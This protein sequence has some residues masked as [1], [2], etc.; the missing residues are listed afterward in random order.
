MARG[1]R[2][3]LEEKIQAK[4]ELIAALQT[5]V[6]SEQRELEELFAEKRRRELEIVND[7]IEESGLDV[8]EV[9]EVL[10]QYIENQ[11]ASAS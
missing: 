11:A 2:K 3:T 4:Q 5:R 6:E 10:Q 1:Q 8:E 9:A 7:L